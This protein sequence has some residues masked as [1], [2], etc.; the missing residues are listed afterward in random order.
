MA[1]ETTGLPTHLALVGR[2]LNLSNTDDLANTFLET[3]YLA[4]VT[5][6]TLAVVLQAGLR[7]S[8]PDVAYRQAYGLVRAD[9]LGAWESAIREATT[10]PVAGYLGPEFHQLLAWATRRRTKLEDDWFKTAFDA[11][12]AV[13]S[14]TWLRRPRSHE[15]ELREGPANRTCSDTQQD[16]SPR[17]SR[18][19]LLRRGKFSLPCG[20]VLRRY[21]PAPLCPGDGCIFQSASQARIA[22]S[23]SSARTPNTSKRLTHRDSPSPNPASTLSQRARIGPSSAATSFAAIATATCSLYP[24]AKPPRQPRPSS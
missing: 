21:D 14:R 20:S 10:Q 9:G 1:I 11:A 3:S 17:G 7:S 15:T 19:R 24:T 18:T 22:L 2:R 6:K 13:T 8:A 23:T 5:I 16:Q 4:E 12:G